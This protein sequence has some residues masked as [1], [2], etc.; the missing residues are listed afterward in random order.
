MNS[1]LSNMLGRPEL[2]PGFNAVTVS[3]DGTASPAMIGGAMF[4]GSVNNSVSGDVSIGQTAIGLLIGGI[5]ALGL[6]YAGTR[7]AQK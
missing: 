7:G 6:R 3:S 2:A 4:Q 5:L 1:G